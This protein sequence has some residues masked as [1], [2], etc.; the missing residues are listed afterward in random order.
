MRIRNQLS[1]YSQRGIMM[2]ET[3]IG[4]II[5][6][7]GVLAMMAL[8]TTAIAVQSDAQYRIEAA[9]YA[10]SILGQ[11]QLGV[12][13]TSAA[14]M[15]NS[16]ATFIHQPAGTNCN[17]SGAASTAPLV[18]AWASAI[19]SSTGKLLPGSTTAMQQI[20]VD[21]A[22]SNQVTITICWQGPNDKIP[23]RHTIVSYVN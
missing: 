11:I 3:L 6:L 19:T 20:L 12:D 2:L 9:N 8:Q 21:P 7:V 17:Y 13:R 16:L 18:T 4:L 14:N 10:Q 5:F 22:T 1:G 23:R 15:Q